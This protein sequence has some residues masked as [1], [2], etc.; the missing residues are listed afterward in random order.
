MGNA[1]TA[2]LVTTSIGLSKEPSTSKQTEYKSHGQI[3]CGVS[4]MRG[5][6]LTMEDKHIVS[7]GDDHTLPGGMVLREHHIFSVFDG[8]GGSDTSDYL[9]MNFFR[10]FKEEIV[11]Y[12]KLSDVARSDVPGIEE[13]KDALRRTFHRLDDELRLAQERQCGSTAVM[14]VLTPTHIVAANVG[15]SRAIL[16]RYGKCIPLTFDHKP[17]KIT[18]KRRIHQA[19]FKIFKKRVQGEL[20]VSRAFGDFGHKPA[21][22]CDPEIL[23]YPRDPQGD[24]FI[25]LACDGVWDVA[26][27]AECCDFIQNLLAEGEVN[28][29]S[30]CEEAID[31]CVLDRHSKDNITLML[32]GMESIK[33]DR[34]NQARNA[35]LGPRRVRQVNSLVDTARSYGCNPELC[36]R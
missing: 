8:H 19:G 31:T 10:V 22:I 4:S 35:V 34:S 21:V 5:W 15:D 18:E 29:G 17:T 20:A 1:V 14:V 12:V 30:L 11:D 3:Q 23:V 25:V 28:L 27:N 2:S 7:L 26:T 24:E 9:E 6:R 13:L 36:V 16:K 32:V 33:I